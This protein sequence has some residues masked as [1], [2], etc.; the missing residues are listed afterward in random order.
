MSL[1]HCF[2]FTGGGGHEH[3]PVPSVLMLPGTADSV[4]GL[5]DTLLLV[6]QVYQT[7][8]QSRLVK[9]SGPIT[10]NVEAIWVLAR[11]VRF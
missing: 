8:I 9:R 7:E 3:E 6:P 2:L 10:P 4:S 5:H 1:Q 11:L